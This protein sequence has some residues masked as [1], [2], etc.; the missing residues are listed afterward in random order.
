MK[1]RNV[2]LVSALSVTVLVA[3]SL[4]L[5]GLPPVALGA[6]ALDTVRRT[7]SPRG[8]PVADLREAATG[9]DRPAPCQRGGAYLRRTIRS[10]R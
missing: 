1:R 2:V 7:N 4:Y 9:T 8:T 5:S 3:L 6:I 10:G